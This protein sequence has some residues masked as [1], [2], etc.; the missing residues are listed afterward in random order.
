MREEKL[1]VGVVEYT[2]P[3]RQY[4][5]ATQFAARRLSS[6]FVTQQV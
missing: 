4:V 3:G 6:L 1:T 5:M 2:A